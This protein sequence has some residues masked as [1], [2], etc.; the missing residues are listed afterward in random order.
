MDEVPTENL[1]RKRAKPQTIDTKELICGIY[2][3]INKSDRTDYPKFTLG[4][5]KM[6]ASILY[7]KTDEYIV[8]FIKKKDKR[9]V[10]DLL[11]YREAQRQ[12]I[13]PEVSSINN[14]KEKFYCEYINCGFN[15][16]KAAR[17]CGYPPKY[18]KQ[19]GYRIRRNLF[20]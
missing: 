4:E 2:N 7:Q 12:G 13:L 19:T 5:V 15:A 9:A 1:K 20:S 18:A 3:A 14:R 10:K 17:R 11:G 6:M 16:A 8:W